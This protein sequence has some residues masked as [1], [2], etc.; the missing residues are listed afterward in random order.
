LRIKIGT[1]PPEQEEKVKGETQKA[2]TRVRHKG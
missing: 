1:L 2:D